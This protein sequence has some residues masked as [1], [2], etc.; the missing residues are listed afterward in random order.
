MEDYTPGQ[1]GHR[2][3]KG[4]QPRTQCAGR[5]HDVQAGAG[6]RVGRPGEGQ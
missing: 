6:E 5:A 3:H 2:T 4:A 1:A